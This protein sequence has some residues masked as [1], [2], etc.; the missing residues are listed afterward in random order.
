MQQL[1]QAACYGL[2]LLLV[3]TIGV[4]HG[5]LMFVF[6]AL[7]AVA[8]ELQACRIRQLDANLAKTLRAFRLTGK[9]VH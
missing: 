5:W 1:K 2:T 9:N 4:K 3:I 6:A 8:I 7:V